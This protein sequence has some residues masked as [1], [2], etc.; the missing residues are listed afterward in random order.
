MCLCLHLTS[1]QRLE[2]STYSDASKFGLQTM[3]KAPWA[4]EGNGLV[5]WSILTLI[6]TV[7]R[8]L[9][10]FLAQRLSVEHADLFT[11][12]ITLQVETASQTHSSQREDH[13]NSKPPF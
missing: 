8:L 2:Q 3:L 7:I 5:S 1:A 6:R 4:Y 13:L 11:P 12:E 10:S 9:P